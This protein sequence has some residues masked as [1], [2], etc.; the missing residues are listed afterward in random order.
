MV[1]CY[2]Q[3][4]HQWP[5]Q[6][7]PPPWPPPPPLIST[8]GWHAKESMVTVSCSRWT[9]LRWD[10]ALVKQKQKNTAHSEHVLMWARKAC[11]A[12]DPGPRTPQDSPGLPYLHLGSSPPQKTWWGDVQTLNPLV[13]YFTRWCCLATNFYSLVWCCIATD[14]CI[15]SIYTAGLSS[16]F[17]LTLSYYTVAHVVALHELDPQLV[18]VDQHEL[19]QCTLLC[20]GQ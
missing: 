16:D 15:R 10:R 14:F 9:H 12:Q 20:G 3:V 19:Y 5:S 2:R 6:R 13:D 7:S 17:C 11:S 18:C 1:C 8:T 4:Q